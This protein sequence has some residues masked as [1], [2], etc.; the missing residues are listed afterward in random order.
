MHKPFLFLAVMFLS[1]TVIAQQFP[2]KKYP[3]GYF[4]YPVGAPVGLVANFGELRP[5]HYH[6]G[7]DCRTEKKENMPVYAAAAGYIAK[8]KIEPFGFGRAIY[9]NHPNGLTTLYAHLNNFFPEL[10]AYVKQQQ[11]AHQ[12]WSLFID[13]PPSLFPVTQ[14]QFIAYSGNTGGSQGP[15]V[16]FEIRDTKTDKVINPLLFGFPIQDNVPPV[17][18]R[19]AVYDRCYST[20]D[21]T[22][23]I[24]SVKKS[25]GVYTTVPGVINISTERVSFGI[26]ATDQLSGSANPNGI[27][28]AFIYDNGKL[29]SGFQLDSISYTETRYLNA[30]IDYKTKSSGGPYIQHLSRLPGYPE[31]VYKDFSGDGVIELED[32]S[33]HSINIVVKDAYGNS[34][35]VKFMIKRVGTNQ[36]RT[37]AAEGTLFHPGYVNIFENDVARLVTGTATLYD[38][39]VFTF[40]QKP[41]IKAESVSPVYALLNGNIPAHDSMSISIKADSVAAE[42]ADR[43]LMQWSWKNKTK[44]AKAKNEQGW[45]KTK[46]RNFGNFQLVID[47][48]PP[49]INSSN[50][51]ENSNLSRAAQ[52][53]IYVRDNYEDIRNFRAELDGK[54]L[55][56]TND[57]EG[58][59][60]YKFDEMC[61]PGTHRLKIT[62]EDV[63]GNV[64]TRTFNFTR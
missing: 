2:V 27:Y 46:F 52:I 44:I 26:T 47:D 37:V 7:L 50:L 1:S 9:I 51:F 32:S 11:Y 14:K 22:P 21:Q 41:A 53:V 16:H 39:V 49:V 42:V 13:I 45:Y 35:E 38:S 23:R 64:S 5:D 18:A 55:R 28:E 10:E 15:H 36:K 57:K 12:S 8:V 48:K 62:A 56:F 20:Y 58:A 33:V 63:A 34:S 3:R 6:M 60:I 59:F 30:N 29:L 61:P 31:S 4:I 17:I 54:W 19:L 24:I 25:E 40:S 43:V